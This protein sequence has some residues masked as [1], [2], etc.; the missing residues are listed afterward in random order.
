ML[1]IPTFAHLLANHYQ[2]SGRPTSRSLAQWAAGSSPFGVADALSVQAAEAIEVQLTADDV[3]WK[4][5][6]CDYD[7]FLRSH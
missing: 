3:G 2:V 1:R 6:G 7:R 4:I 5:V